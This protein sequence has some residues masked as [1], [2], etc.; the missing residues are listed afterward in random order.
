HRIQTRS[1]A[2]QVPHG[3]G[4]LVKINVR[5]QIG[6]LSAEQLQKRVD[7]TRSVSGRSVDLN[8]IARRK[9]NNF[10]EMPKAL[11]HKRK[12]GR[13]RLFDC[14]LFAQFNWRRLMT[15]SGRKEFHL[16]WS[17]WVRVVRTG[18]SDLAWLMGAALFVPVQLADNS[19]SAANHGA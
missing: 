11:Q 13:R 15:Y 8:A 12:I 14:E 18:L 10:V 4:A 6:R 19:R 16:T 1:D 2:E 7:V 5:T 9:Q 17:K 3:H